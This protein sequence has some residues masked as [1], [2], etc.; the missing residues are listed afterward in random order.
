MPVT[1]VL[2]G[3]LLA[4]SFAAAAE[5]NTLK[6]KKISGEL[7]SADDKAIVIKTS[8]GDVATPVPEAMQLQLS[9]QT[10]L[11]LPDKYID[12]ELIDGTLFHCAGFT[13][14]GKQVELTVVPQMKLTVPMSVVAFI[15]MDAQDPRTQKEWQEVIADR[16]KRDRFFVR[17][18]NR[19]DGL[20]GTFGDA[21]AAG[22]QIDFDLAT[23]A[24][25]KLPVDRLAALMFNNRLEGN[26]PPTV[27]R[28]SDAY[29]NSI[30]ANKAVFKDGKLT[31]T[32][33]VGV[34]VE[35]PSLQQL[36]LLDYSQDKVV[37]LSEMKCREENIFDESIVQCSRDHNLDGQ[38]IQLDGVLYPRGMVIHAGMALNFDVGGEYKEFRT[39]LGFDSSSSLVS[40]VKVIFEGDGRP[41]FTQEVKVKEKPQPLTL[42]IKKV[43]QLKVTVLPAEGLFIGRQVTLANAKVSK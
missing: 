5:L 12:V 2:F 30:I 3:L 28:V 9:S 26:I 17:K 7:V 25:R 6:G 21:D 1:R 33:V 8:G 23:G 16:G 34:S 29:K 4:G 41:L 32:S 22:K 39:V 14:K 11:K 35:Y 38:P 27:C 18:D 40:N 15:L 13:L 37:Y 10:A 36:A 31:L 43:K 19:L 24:R 42:D 20:D